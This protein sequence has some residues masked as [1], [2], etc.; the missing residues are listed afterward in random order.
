MNRLLKHPWIVIAVCLAITVG[1]GIQL[2]DI[3]LNNSLRQFFPQKH[4]SYHRLTDAEQ[5]FGS[6]SAIGIALETDRDSI[7]TPEYI[8]IIKRITTRVEA[9]DNV[10]S[11]DSLSDIDYVYGADGSLIAGALVADDFGG[12]TEEVE[13]V[14]QKLTDWDDMYNRVVIS[15]DGRAAQLQ[16]VI[17]ADCT[18]AETETLL[19]AVKTIVTEEVTDPSLS[20]RIYGDAVLNDNARTFMLSDLTRLIPLVVLVVLL[21]LFFSFKTFDGTVLPLITVLISTIWSCGLMAIFNVTFTI[22]SS[23]IPVALIAV[24]SAYG[25][26]V[27]THYY[28]AL[29]A[30][31][32]EMTKEKH[33]AAIAAG[34][35]DVWIAVL[36]AG[37]TT[38]I[39]FISLI[40][41]PLAPLHSFAVFAALGV[42][43][44]L[45]LSVVLIPALLMIK[46]VS[47]IGKKSR[48]MEKLTNKVKAKINAEN[49][50][51]NLNVESGSTLY[52][53]YHFFAGTKGRLAFFSVVIVIASWFGVK[54]LVI[55]TSL[56]NYF[57]ADSKFRQDISYVDDRFAGTNSLYFVVSGPEK[58]SMNNPELLKPLD[59]MQNYLLAKYDGIG[60]IVSFTTFIKRMNQVMHIPESTALAAD[61]GSAD[62]GSSD[63]LSSFSSFGDDS[64]SSFGDDQLGSFGFSDGLSS[65]DDA[66]AAVPAETKVFVDPNIAYGEKLQQPM[67]VQDGLDMLNKAYALAGGKNA[68]VKDI[69][70]ILEREL[71]Y[72]GVD[73]YEIPY[74]PDKYP[75]ATRAELSDL[76]SQYLLL[77][78][79]SLDRFADDPLS[80][81][82][83]RVMAQ[84]RTHSTIT[85]G[86]II[87]DAQNY[88]ARYFPEGYTIEAT[89]N[90]EME[91]VM[92]DLIVTSQLQS[93]I[94]SL[95]CVFLIISVAFKSGFA[96]LL[97][98]VPLAFA[99]ILNYMIMGFTGIKLDLVTSIIASV[100]V[101]VGIDY[102][103]HFLTTYKTERALS[104]DLQLVTRRTLAKS[105]R[106]I[107]TNA[108]AVGLGFLVLYFSEFVVLRYIGIL[109]AIVMFSSSMLAMTVIPGFL[110]I[111]DPKF[112]RP[113]QAEVKSGETPK[114][115]N[116]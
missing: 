107:V 85:V 34:V 23:V 83:L 54:Q 44:S 53:V 52:A 35:K 105:G 36:L 95:V 113:K 42:G 69:V 56:V 80:P 24:G 88:A 50:K 18:P 112:I 25:I 101:G 47:K 66:A 61:A 27:L 16:A 59:D 32:G 55:D 74:D 71:N 90:A 4:D 108:L 5:K 22:V 17:K 106:G 104:D 58:G 100:A 96:G 13:A 8:D 110:N 89:G 63:D 114:P 72:N 26:H 10:E 15:D 116:V 12:S 11:V 40:T 20:V 21:S 2:V 102:T 1:L 51:K 93:L 91:Y 82:S 14:R 67:T 78:S 46:P 79:G 64:F 9:L 94:F 43:F 86:N 30:V 87:D 28:I 65:F 92:T 19:S 41:S 39:G 29:E 70:Q 38:I 111:F 77:F 31:D 84:L 109:V 76:V 33:A 68:T 49:V 3:E 115:E 81:Q 99:I 57:P 48:R 6:M 73:Y 103:I 62:I 60:K 45:I 7:V 97:G 75:A 98:A 37:V